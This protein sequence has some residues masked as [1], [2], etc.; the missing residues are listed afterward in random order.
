MIIAGEASG[1]LHGSKLVLAMREKNSD[2]FFCGIGGQALRDAGVKIIVDASQLSVVG[3]SEVFSKMPGLFRGMSVAKKL[4]KS[5]KPDLLIII[6]FPDFNLHIAGT[7]KKLGIPVLYYISPQVW[8][9]RPGRVKKI[10]KIVD[11]VAVILPFEEKFFK[12]HQV[13]ATFVGHPLLDT[14]LFLEGSPTE[15]NTEDIPVIG[16][17]PG[18]R[19]R[20]IE[21]LLPVMLQSARILLERDKNMKFIV[22]VAPSIE[23]KIVETIVEE[24]R[25]EY[26]FELVSEPVESFLKRCRLAVVASGTVTLEA[27]IYGI[28]MIIIYKMSPVTYWLGRMLVR[29]RVKYFGLVNLIAGREISP[30]LLQGEASSKKIADVA[31]EMLNDVSGLEKTRK[32]LLGI[33]DVLGGS[34]AS[35]RV[36]DIALNM[37][38][39]PKPNDKNK[40][41][42]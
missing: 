13:Q 11:H 42:T 6:D 16:F 32:E 15:I 35:K 31:F 22:S 27:A 7:A 5:L 4:L 30:E 24:H 38:E 36:A 29:S 28:P 37:L 12:K 23:R 40:R 41:Q 17:L 20:E 34:G 18:S 9:W 26:D 39:K 8:A 10:R 1:D 3:I 25:G 21:T 14:H 19:D 33:K 2:L